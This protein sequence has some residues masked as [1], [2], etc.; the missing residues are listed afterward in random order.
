MA[1]AVCADATPDSPQVSISHSLFP[2]PSL[3]VSDY[4]WNFVLWPL[5]RFSAS[6]AISPW[7]TRNPAAQLDVIWVPF[8][9]WCCRLGSPTWRLDP[10][11][12]EVTP[13]LLKYPSNMSAATHEPS[14]PSHISSTLPTSHIVVKWFLLSVPWLYSFPLPSVHSVVIQDDFSTI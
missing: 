2:F 5:R 8:P 12:L 3:R 10:L 6:L 4:K 1:S 9:V 11:F 13:Q 14:Q 7:Q